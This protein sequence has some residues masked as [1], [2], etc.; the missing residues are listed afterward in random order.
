MSLV[1]YLV[2]LN[3]SWGCTTPFLPCI[4]EEGLISAESEMTETS[5]FEFFFYF[6][7]LSKSVLEAS[8]SC[9]I[10][11]LS[12][13]C[14]E[15]SASPGTDRST[16]LVDVIYRLYFFWSAC[17]CMPSRYA[18]FS[19]SSKSTVFLWPRIS[20]IMAIC[21]LTDF[22]GLCLYYVTLFPVFFLR[23]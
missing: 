15:G 2:S 16:V 20:Y 23:R 11:E 22:S 4:A 12:G 17:F 8:L 5:Y 21:S 9:L 19:C 7:L 1:T 14:K 13:L 6:L 3:T 18:C 10:F